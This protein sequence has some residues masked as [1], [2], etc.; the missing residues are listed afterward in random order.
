VE[1]KRRAL[2]DKEERD[3]KLAF[4]LYDMTGCGVITREDAMNILT[5]LGYRA[6]REDNL[7]LNA[8]L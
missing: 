5:T 2:T 4:E 7:K 1:E 3:I 8:I 6:T